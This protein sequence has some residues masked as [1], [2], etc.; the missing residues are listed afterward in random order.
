[1]NSLRLLTKD[2]P[3][4][5]PD[6]TIYSL[7]DVHYGAA[8]CNVN[9]LNE[10]IKMIRET[11]RA[12]IVC[13]GDLINNG[14]KSSKTNSYEETITPAEQKY[15]MIELLRPIQDRILV[16][17]SGNHEYR[18]NRETSENPCRDIA[19]ALQVPYERDGA[20][21][22]VTIGKDKKAKRIPY[23]IY[24][25]HGS[26]G[27]RKVSAGMNNAE[28]MLYSLDGVDIIV[29]GHTHKLT[30]GRISSLRVDPQ[31][32]HVKQVEKLI[33][34][35]GSWL[36]YSGYAQRGMYKPSPIGP[37]VIKLSGTAKEF[38]SII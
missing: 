27:G 21:L 2:F 18:S 37:A 34:I 29:T 24:V 36:D 30:A 23:I 32:N 22:K 6:V 15:H 35:S 5:W 7:S 16:I 17:V 13:A 10:F 31:N 20:F 3:T 28:D 4:D 19:A 9:K 26:G 8:E 14:I 25:T 1:V 33:V 38:H 12:Y 11:P